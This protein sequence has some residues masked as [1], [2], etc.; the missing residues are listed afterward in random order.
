MN[1]LSNL[2]LN[3]TTGAIIFIII[4]VFGLMSN[5]FR[6]YILIIIAIFIGVTMIRYI[7]YLRSN[8]R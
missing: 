2:L 7:Y 3:K 1:L 5:V 4:I 6:G 8:E